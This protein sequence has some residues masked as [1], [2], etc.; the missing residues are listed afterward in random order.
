MQYSKDGINHPVDRSLDTDPAKY[1][2]TINVMRNEKNRNQGSFCTLFQH[3]HLHM[4]IIYLKTAPVIHTNATDT[5]NI[6]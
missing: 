1:L 2:E 3:M 5:I 4:K 6:D